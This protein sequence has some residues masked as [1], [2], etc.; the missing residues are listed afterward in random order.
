MQRRA[1]S[2]GPERMA[3]PY[4]LGNFSS[5]VV[6]PTTNGHSPITDAVLGSVRLTLMALLHPSDYA[7]LLTQA[8]MSPVRRW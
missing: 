2:G 5:H 1:D 3:S 4:G 7:L 8:T 6:D